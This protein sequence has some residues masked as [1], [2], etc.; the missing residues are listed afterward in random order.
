MYSSK[1]FKLYSDFRFFSHLENPEKMKLQIKSMVSTLRT[2]LA[3]CG[4]EGTFG[5]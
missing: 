2:K 1:I 5:H 4:G 3:L